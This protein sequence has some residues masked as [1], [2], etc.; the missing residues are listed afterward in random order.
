MVFFNLFSSFQDNNMLGWIYMRERERKKN[1]LNVQV[2][3]LKKERGKPFV[4]Q[5]V[6]V[7][8]LE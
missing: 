6:A 8:R 5:S 2:L 4:T 3:E 7:S 1:I